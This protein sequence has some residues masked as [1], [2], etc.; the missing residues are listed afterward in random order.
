MIKSTAIE[1]ATL[2]LAAIKPAAIRSATINLAAI[3][4]ATIMFVVAIVLL[5]VPMSGFA[6]VREIQ[7]ND[8]SVITGEI[9]SYT[10]GVYTVKSATLGTITIND[11]M[12]YSISSKGGSG[13]SASSSPAGSG[14]DAASQAKNLQQRMM[15]DADI[16]N[17]IL[18]LKDDPEI[19]KILQDP[20]IIKAVNN[21][22]LQKLSTNPKFLSLLNNPKVQEIERKMGK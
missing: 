15:S 8:G 5:T 14:Q 16:M 2:K 18:S 12:V 4:L 11:S 20:E 13:V 7:L 9:I 22:D 21:N 3:K 19:Q 17:I 1:P 6:G 10:N